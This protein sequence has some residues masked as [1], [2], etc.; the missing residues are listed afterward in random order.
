MSNRL[1]QIHHR[2][3][4]NKYFKKYFCFNRWNFRIALFLAFSNLG[5]FLA[6]FLRKYI[7]V[8]PLQYIFVGVPVFFSFF[9]IRS[10][11]SAVLSFLLSFHLSTFLKKG[12]KNNERRRPLSFWNTS[13]SILNFKCDSILVCLFLTFLEIIFRRLQLLLLL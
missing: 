2:S 3:L 4:G 12:N 1:I 5:L 7:F 13:S 11:L 8:S 9:V 6:F 10:F